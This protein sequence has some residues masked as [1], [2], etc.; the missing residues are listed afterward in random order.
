MICYATDCEAP[1]RVA[2]L[3]Q[4]HYATLRRT[5]D[6]NTPPKRKR[7]PLYGPVCTIDG[8][9]RAHYAKGWCSKHYDNDRLRGDPL[10]EGPGQGWRP[11]KFRGE[12]LVDGCSREPDGSRGYCLAHYHR[13]LKHGDP[14]LA[15]VKAKYGDGHINR[16]GYREIYVGG[17]RVLE[18]RHVMAQHLGRPLLKGEEVHHRNGQRADNRLENLELWSHSQPAGQRIE[19]KV[20]WAKQLLAEYG[21]TA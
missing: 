2:G 18:H 21:E 16:L 7:K 3:C 1:P 4:R 6:P 13:I 8:C 19:D 14:G 17:V 9:D 12:C 11:K 15:E 10:A 5:G 20:A